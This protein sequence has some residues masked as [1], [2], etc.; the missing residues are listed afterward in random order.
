[1]AGRGTSAR[2]LQRAGLHVQNAAYLCQTHG[3]AGRDGVG[4]VELQG[5]CA[6]TSRSVSPRGHPSVRSHCFV[7][8]H[9]KDA[10]VAEAE[11]PL[12]ESSYR[13][14]DAVLRLS[15]RFDS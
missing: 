8:A 10:T 7:R 14:T 15:Q 3:I 12:P 13:M 6:M 11:R 4:G 9:M 2:V 1:M 5:G